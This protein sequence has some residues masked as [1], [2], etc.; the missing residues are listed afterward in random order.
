MRLKD[1]SQP[2]QAA[3]Q[4]KIERIRSGGPIQPP[5][6]LKPQP[7]LPKPPCAACVGCAKPNC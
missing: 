3:L 7:G 6:P 5:A 4:A 2:M 1:L